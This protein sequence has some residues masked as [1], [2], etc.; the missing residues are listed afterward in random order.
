MQNSADTVS[1]ATTDLNNAKA[2]VRETEAEI[3]FRII[4]WKPDQADSLSGF[5]FLAF[6]AAV[7]RIVPVSGSGRFIKTIYPLTDIAGKDVLFPELFQR[8]IPQIFLTQIPVSDRIFCNPAYFRDAQK[9][10]QC[11]VLICQRDGPLSC[12]VT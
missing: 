10:A 12:Y 9:A 2:G 4:G 11:A 7:Q 5:I 3:R 1:K 6:F 8:F